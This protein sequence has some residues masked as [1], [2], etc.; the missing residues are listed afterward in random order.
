MLK[1]NVR[2]NNGDLGKRIDMQIRVY[3][4][5]LILTYLNRVSKYKLM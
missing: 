1:R 4:G 3:P 2:L 5:I